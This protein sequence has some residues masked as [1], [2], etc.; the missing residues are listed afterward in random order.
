MSPDSSEDRSPM[1]PHWA[2]AK[3][4]LGLRTYW[5]ELRSRPFPAFRGSRT[6]WPPARP[7]LQGSSTSPLFCCLVSSALTRLLS[8]I[9]TPC[10]H[11]PPSVSQDPP[12]PGPSQSLISAM[13][14]FTFPG[15]RGH[16]V[17]M[18][19][20]GGGIPGADGILWEGSAASLFSGRLS[21]P[22]W[23]EWVAARGPKGVGVPIGW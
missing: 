7:C 2:K 23:E 9:R 13:R 17:D 21:R 3:V 11:W 6:P 4:C 8:P 5:G 20:A 10:R 16:G 18:G 12:S 15:S 22:G 19:R 14:G 1:Q